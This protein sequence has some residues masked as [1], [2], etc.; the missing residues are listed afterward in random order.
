MLV[1]LPVFVGVV[2]SVVSFPT[3]EAFPKVD[4][5]VS[6]VTVDVS[7]VLVSSVVDRL[8][9]RLLSRNCLIEIEMN[10]FCGPLISACIAMPN[11][12]VWLEVGFVTSVGVLHFHFI[13]QTRAAWDTRNPF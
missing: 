1:G 12:L 7:V 11:N 9:V 8:N 4:T 2:C 10:F 13:F 6:S 3:V 5:S